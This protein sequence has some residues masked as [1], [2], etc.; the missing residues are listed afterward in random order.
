M[1]SSLRVMVMVYH[2]IS[3]TIIWLC[4]YQSTIITSKIEYNISAKGNTLKKTGKKK[5]LVHE[6][7]CN[8]F[9][10]ASKQRQII[11]NLKHEWIV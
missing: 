2:L 6:S 7:E 1:D 3:A 11:N 5:S 10:F 9:V 4:L 8:L